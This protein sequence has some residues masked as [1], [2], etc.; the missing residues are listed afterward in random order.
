MG[1]IGIPELLAI[2]FVVMFGGILVIL[3]FW[4]IFTKAGF[5]GWMSLTQ[6]IPLVNVIALFYLA[7]AEWP[8]HRDHA[9]LGT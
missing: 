6:I 4:M 8:I 2:G 7:F 3:P 5:S 1:P 9:R